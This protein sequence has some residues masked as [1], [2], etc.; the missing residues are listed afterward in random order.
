M[1]SLET[2]KYDVSQSV[3]RKLAFN[4]WVLFVLKKRAHIISLIKQSSAHYL[5]RNQKY[6]IYLPRTVEE[7][8]M[9]D[10]GNGRTLWYDAIAK[11]MT[12]IK[13]AFNILDVDESIQRNHQFVKRYM[14]F[15]LKM[16]NFI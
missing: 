1:N 15:N 4:W 11:E 16:E 7:A 9:I 10:K 13:V 2:D 8:L 12:N 5:K 3:E 14:I 6:G